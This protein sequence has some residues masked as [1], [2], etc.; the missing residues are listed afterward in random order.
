MS[1][2]AQDS[3]PPQGIIELFPYFFPSES[4]ARNTDAWGIKPGDGFS[5][6]RVDFLH[7]FCDKAR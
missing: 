2:P 3:V 4:D 5:P 6:V 7:I 1:Y